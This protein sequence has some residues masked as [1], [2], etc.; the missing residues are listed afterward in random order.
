MIAWRRLPVPPGY[1]REWREGDTELVTLRGAEDSAREALRDGTLYDFAAHAPGARPMRGRGTAFAVSLPD[2]GPP[3]VVR[4]SRHGGLLAGV[5]GERFL[6]PT[7]APRELRTALWLER[8]G[9]PTPEVIAYATYPAGSAFRRADIA[10]RE[11]EGSRHLGQLLTDTAPG[12]ERTESWA[13][14]GR[15]LAN[16]SA[17]GARHPD[18]NAANVLLATGESGETKAWLLDVDRVWFDR[19]D[20]PRVM[21]ANLRRLARSVRKWRDRWGAQIE[22]AELEILARQAR[23][24][25]T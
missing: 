24:P 10:T 12:A 20:E 5:T 14:V 8:A 6:A 13:A 18:L 4:R 1:V 17:A 9:V 16:L 25:G 7:R 19:P 22:E 3:V 15:L 21:E 2:G 23:S 11:V